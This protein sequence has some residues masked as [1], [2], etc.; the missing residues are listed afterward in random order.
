[1]TSGIRS[2]RYLKSQQ[3][4]LEITQLS[5]PFPAAYKAEPAQVIAADDGKMLVRFGENAEDQVLILEL[6]S[7][8]GNTL[9]LDCSAYFE[10]T[11]KVAR[12]ELTPKKVKEVTT[13]VAQKQTIDNL[14]VQRLRVALSQTPQGDPKRREIADNLQRSEAVLAETTQASQRMVT[15][16]ELRQK[17]A[18]G[19][20]IHFR[21]FYQADD[22][23]V[24]LLQTAT[25]G[26]D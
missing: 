11:P 5:A 17:L 7:Q 25:A 3:L 10:V 19:A 26:E 12:I 24:D 9:R 14:G 23:E 1:M 13:F 21:L 15:L 2:K 18:A 8:L 16:A 6:K 20:A 4:R 22:C